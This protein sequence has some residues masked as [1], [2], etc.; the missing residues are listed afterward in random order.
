[1]IQ[2]DPETDVFAM[3]GY[4]YGSSLGNQ[5]TRIFRDEKITPADGVEEEFIQIMDNILSDIHNKLELM[6]LRTELRSRVSG[7]E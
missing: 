6:K 1:M 7:G 4:C 2:N 3:L 5:L